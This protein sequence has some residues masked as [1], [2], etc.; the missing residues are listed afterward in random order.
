MNMNTPRLSAGRVTATDLGDRLRESAAIM[1]I[2][3]QIDAERRFGVWPPRRS[4]ALT[5]CSGPCARGL[6]ACPAPDAC[7][8]MADSDADGFGFW[9]GMLVAVG[10]A[11]LVAACVAFAFGLDW[12]FRVLA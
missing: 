1:A 8:R 9:R 12:L 6:R 3:D 7:E 4:P 10:A 5:Q 2:A 11:F